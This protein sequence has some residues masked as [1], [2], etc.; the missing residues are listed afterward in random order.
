MKL[1][2][3]LAILSVMMILIGQAYSEQSKHQSSKLERKIKTNNK[4]DPPTTATPVTKDEDPTVVP[5]G[6]EDTRFLILGDT[7]QNDKFFKDYVQR[8][9]DNNVEKIEDLSEGKFS[10]FDSAM[11]VVPKDTY[12]QAIILGDFIYTEMKNKKGGLVLSD[13]TE[14]NKTTPRAV[15][16]LNPKTKQNENVSTI[17]DN[18]VKNTSVYLKNLLETTYK[19]ISPFWLLENGNHSYDVDAALERHTIGDGK[20]ASNVRMYKHSKVHISKHACFAD[21]NFGDVV[22][23]NKPYVKCFEGPL[24]SARYGRN[25][26]ETT[27]SLAKIVEAVLTLKLCKS[28]WRIIRTHAAPY[29]TET[30]QHY[31]FNKINGK[32]QCRVRKAIEGLDVSATEFKDLSEVLTKLEASQIDLTSAQ[33]QTYSPAIDKK[34]KPKI[35]NRI[36]ECKGETDAWK[37]AP[38]QYSIMEIVNKA[39]PHFYLGSHLHASQ[40][41]FAPKEPQ[42][43][44]FN[45]FKPSEESKEPI[46]GCKEINNIK[47]YAFE[48][49]KVQVPKDCDKSGKTVEDTI[50]IKKLN[51]EYNIVF[52]IGNSGRYLD[53]FFTGLESSSFVVWQRINAPKGLA[54]QMMSAKKSTVDQIL[55]ADSHTAYGYADLEFHSNDKLTISYIEVDREDLSKPTPKVVLKLTLDKEKDIT[56]PTFTLN[57]YNKDRD[58][59]ATSK[60]KLK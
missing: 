57:N 37:K 47:T 32:L 30:D 34:N 21:L 12:K 58:Q 45:G 35:Q 28:K 4:L 9:V 33:L 7:G 50:Q 1:F 8:M 14:D 10:N 36:F 31:L 23:L 60:R 17:F 26:E 19:G 29:N 39:A 51:P 49:G 53:N 5:F 25:E 42:S 41:L 16:Y 15:N 20:E 3:T 22:C 40:V 27:D 48:A 54:A 52:V 13:V 44:N 24:G 2:T 6:A 38:S 43:Y 59:K 18:R 11:N 55:E 46:N 56:A